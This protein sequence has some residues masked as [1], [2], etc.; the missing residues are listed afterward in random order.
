MIALPRRSQR[1]L[2]LCPVDNDVSGRYFYQ[3]AE[4]GLMMMINPRTRY[5]FFWIG[6]R[7]VDRRPIRI[8]GLWNRLL[9]LHRRGWSVSETIADTRVER[10]AKN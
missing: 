8:S 7:G 3:M 1:S 4:T 5:E 6:W 9:S 10:K 2:I